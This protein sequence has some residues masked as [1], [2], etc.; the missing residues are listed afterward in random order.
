M[1]DCVIELNDSEIRVARGNKVLHRSPGYAIVRGGETI[2]GEKALRQARLHPRA[3][4]NRFWSSLNE[5]PL[6]TGTDQVR[7]NADLVYAHLRTLHELAGKP[8]EVIFAVP[9]DLTR[10]QLALLLGIAQACGFTS[11]GLVDSAVAAA[12]ATVGPGRYV[13]VDVQL[14]RV[15]ITRL[16]VGEMV[17]R[18][19][20]D[21]I[22]DAGVVPIHDASASLIADAF[23]E[24]CRFDPLHH[25]ETEQALYDQLAQ[26][27]KTLSERPEVSLEIE[28]RGSR[29]LAKLKRIALLDVL[30]PRYAEIIRRLD[31]DRSVLLSSRLAALPAFA[32]RVAGAHVL[33]ANAVFSG[34]AVHLNV[35]RSSGV[36]VSFITRLPAAPH[37]TVAAQPND[38]ARAT[39]I[40]TRA[41][42]RASHL[43]GGHR[44]YSLSGAPLYL[45]AAGR[46][47]RAREGAT[48]CSVGL[49]GR[50]AV[51]VP[52]S[53]ITIYVN[54]DRLTGMRVLS[55]GDKISFAGSEAVFSLISAVESGAS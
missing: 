36:D 29:H 31:T 33:E 46:V 4:Y 2:L 7:H 25:A 53:D 12:A 8:K 35:I 32:E 20:I 15:V 9:G 1:T 21:T 51:I 40:N 34:C 45:S 52:L 26:C 41:P 44:A 17:A 18:E 24:Q 48:S 13:H 39:D 43:L 37:A 19:S 30:A 6:Q 23:I 54:G 38:E 22:D 16:A 50:H 47:A 49:N 5:N 55:P 14:H 10:E 42:E 3:A 11:A 28:F 27:L